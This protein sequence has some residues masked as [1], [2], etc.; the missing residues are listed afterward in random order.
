M[1]PW[2]PS[3]IGGES[4]VLWK[5]QGV[6]ASHQMH[7]LWTQFY[8]RWFISKALRLLNSYLK[9]GS[10]VNFFISWIHCICVVRIYCDNQN[11]EGLYWN[12]LKCG[13]ASTKWPEIRT[14]IQQT[15]WIWL[16]QWSCWGNLAMVSSHLKHRKIPF[17][18]FL[19][20]QQIE[21]TYG[22]Y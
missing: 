22:F 19:T 6:M 13:Y 12:L 2:K 7:S 8:E 10:V 11:S 4:R 20:N 15:V 18:K 21:N 1:F 9:K 16:F 3:K 5:M 14:S 17:S